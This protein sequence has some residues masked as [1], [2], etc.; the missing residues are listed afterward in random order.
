MLVFDAATGLPVGGD[1]ANLSCEV[2]LDQ[3][4]PAALADTTAVEV[5]TGYYRYALARSETNGNDVRFY[6]ASTTP[7]VVISFPGHDPQTI[8]RA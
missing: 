2:S 1:A 5:R 4:S 6:G 7:G 3:S 8:T